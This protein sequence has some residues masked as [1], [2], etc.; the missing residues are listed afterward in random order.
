MS[1][2]LQIIQNCLSSD[3]ILRNKAEQELLK[4]CDQDLFQIFTQLCNMI[5]EE[6]TPDTVCLF[7]GTFIK[8]IFSTNKYISIWNTFSQEQISLIKNSFLSNLA[9]EK[10]QIK[11]TCSLT[12]AAMA[13]VEIP[14]GWDIIDVICK[15]SVHENINYKITS[16]KTLQ[17]ILDFIGNDILKPY[18]KQSILGALTSNMSTNESVEVIN[19]AIIGFS[20]IIPFVEDNFKNEKER[21]FMINLLLQLLNPSFV[22]KVSLSENIQKNILICLTDI[23]K[24]YAFHITNNFSDIANMSFYYFNCKNIL[25]STLAIELWATVCDEEIKMD[26]KFITDNYQ[27][28]L[29]DSIIRVI[30][31]RK[32][33]SFEEEDE[34]TPT[35]AAVILL[36]DLVNN[37]NLKI[38]NRML[39]YISE[40][41]NNDLLNKFD[42]KE[43]NL[44]KDEIIKAL[45]I[46]ENV[47]LIYRGILSSN[48]IEDNIIE[49]SLVKIINELKNESNIPIAYTISLCLAVICKNHF[50]IINKSQKIFDNFIEEMIK[51]LEFHFNNK[52]IIDGLLLSIKH[53]IKNADIYYFNKHLVNILV[54]LI[55]IAYD[56]KS[57]NKDLNIT[58]MS[59]FLIG[60]IIENCENTK[61]NRNIIQS[62]FADLYTRFLNSLNPNNFSEKE[63]QICYQNCLLGLIVSCGGEYQKIKMDLTQFTSVYNFIE[64]CLQQRGCLFEEA[65]LALGS[66]AYFGWELFSHINNNVMKYI[67]FSLK[68]R[69][70]YQLCYQGLLAADDVIRC[71]GKESIAIIPNIVNEMKNIINDPNIPRG[72]RIKCFGLYNDIFMTED[73][74]NQAYVDDVLP[75][76]I[77]GMRTSVEPPAS[78]MDEDELEYLNELR[79]KI[80]ELVTGVFL[81]LNCHNK[82]NYFSQ[83]IDGFIKYLSKIVEP[84]FNC[85]LDL[86]FDICGLLGDLYKY[87]PGSVELYLSPNSMKIIVEKLEQSPNP[88]HKELL[89]YTKEIMKELISNYM[90]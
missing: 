2:L 42:K 90:L 45:I 34:W 69:Q 44:I 72:L 82:T 46:K 36:S 55:R 76:L 71:V 70:D 59:M 67:L 58:E 19:E 13:K 30:Q 28:N 66:M 40:C 38:T 3:N 73:I 51:I 33:N 41:L 48:D 22:S 27:D 54:I 10:S 64:Q 7:I 80:V 87:F 39:G 16:L 15:A 26:K 49:N 78:N 89:N 24:Y 29:N 68:E 57:Y 75:L 74:S 12:I 50:N 83:Y 6:S 1:F 63:E 53:T 86:I 62:F 84:E 79:E 11:K 18:D 25:L 21:V 20:K 77:N 9:S 32:Y 17:N 37:G 31:S 47:Y 14:K 65:L 5:S 88:E 56:K 35:K 85:K 23:I 60:K 4:C 81:F 8:H 43:K 61:E 52:K